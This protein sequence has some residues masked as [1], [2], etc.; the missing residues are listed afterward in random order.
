MVHRLASEAGD[1]GVDRFLIVDG[2]ADGAR[3]DLV[4]VT[5]AARAKLDGRFCSAH[6]GLGVTFEL[7][8]NFGGSGLMCKL[9]V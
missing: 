2:G 7:T 6:L 5:G 1:S 3:P 4:G 9:A 8:T